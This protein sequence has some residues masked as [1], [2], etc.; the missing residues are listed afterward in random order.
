MPKRANP[1]SSALRCSA[2]AP[3]SKAEVIRACNKVL[4]RMETNFTDA[5]KL[6][7]IEGDM[8]ELKTE[9]RVY[10]LPPNAKHEGQA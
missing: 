6:R 9:G 5:E 1:E 7:F 8:L 3:W 2:A 4:A 10:P